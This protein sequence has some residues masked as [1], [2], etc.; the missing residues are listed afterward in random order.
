MLHALGF[1][2]L[3]YT[4]TRAFQPL[5]IVFVDSPIVSMTCLKCFTCSGSSD[6]SSK[7]KFRLVEAG[8]K[9]AKD[10][11]ASSCTAS[12]ANQGR[13]NKKPA[14]STTCTTMVPYKDHSNRKSRA[15]K[16]VEEE[17]QDEEEEDQVEE[18]A[19]EEEENEE[20]E[21]E[22]GEEDADSNNGSKSTVSRLSK[23]ALSN[24]NKFVE[25][26]ERKKLSEEA[27]LAAMKQA[28]NKTQMSLWKAFEQS[29]KG[30]GLQDSFKEATGSGTGSSIKK[31]TWMVEKPTST[32]SQQLQASRRVPRQVRSLSGFPKWRL[33]GGLAQKSSKKG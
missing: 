26:A 27:S 18:A 10:K 19:D 25:E 32:T 21:E 24:H 30:S 7:G 2:N 17:A 29:R 23:E 15:S 8:G 28:D 4:W 20:E 13:V 33:R 3:N 11:K 14:T 22:E 5:A 6:P 12:E 1:A 16:Q 31:R 9:G